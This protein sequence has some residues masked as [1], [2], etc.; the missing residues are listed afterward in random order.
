L[1]I[2]YDFGLKL[3]DVWLKVLLSPIILEMKAGG[4]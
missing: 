4:G 2:E 1:L 3:V